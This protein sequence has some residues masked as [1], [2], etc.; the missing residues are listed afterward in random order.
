MVVGDKA[1]GTEETSLALQSKV[2]FDT[3]FGLHGNAIECRGFIDPL[4]NRRY[5]RI[6]QQRRTR[7]RLRGFDMTVGADNRG[8]DY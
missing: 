4:L 5:C 1:G 2:Q 3:S 6:L 7:D 8:N